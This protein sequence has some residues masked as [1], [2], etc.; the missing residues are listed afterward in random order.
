MN[1]KTNTV[2]LKFGKRLVRN[3]VSNY[4]AMAIKLVTSIFLAYLL[5][6]GLGLE[7]YG[8]WSLLWAGS[9][10]SLLLDL[11][12]GRAVEKYSAEASFS[13]N[14][15]KFNSIVSTIV[16]GYCL[17]AI[18]IIVVGLLIS[19]NLEY[20][21]KVTN[22]RDI[23]NIAY[24]KKVLALFTVGVAMVFPTGVFPTILL[25]LQRTYLRNYV[26]IGNKIVELAGVWYIFHTEH[27]LMTLIIFT[28]SINLLSNFAMAIMAF[29]LMPG[30][31]FRLKYVKL[32]TIKYIADF[33]LFTYLL[34]I[35]DMIIFQTDRVLL[36]AM[37][38][39]TS[40]GMYHIATKIP[41]LISQASTQFQGNLAPIAA[42]LHKSGD[43]HKLEYMMFHSTRITVFICTGVFAAVIPLVRPILY[44]WLKVTDETTIMLSYILISSMFILIIFRD[45]AKHFL[46]M[47]GH[48]RLITKIAVAESISNIVL[49]IIFIKSMG[50]IGVAIGTLIP[51]VIISLLVI[52]PLAARHSGSSPL[53]YLLKV[54]LPVMLFATPITLTAIYFTHSITPLWRWNFWGLLFSASATGAVYMLVGWVIYI[55]REERLRLC[56]LIPKFVPKK[57]VKLIAW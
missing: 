1:N 38:S 53:P 3:T 46:L 20:V 43:K 21:F 7:F 35:C 17:M 9:L 23:R 24:Y 36:G 37:V 22:G 29:R 45:T 50:I 6:K 34:T 47:T 2:E 4:I 16:F 28:T 30:L 25:G 13:G 56:S 39:I 26:I 11:G 5:L 27:S 32:R 54:Y 18:I 41:Q 40:V 57:L 8:F 42:I 19:L 52:F 33:S 10:Y 48:H 49:S 12:F 44:R 51:N 14:M 31:K 55:N 15:E